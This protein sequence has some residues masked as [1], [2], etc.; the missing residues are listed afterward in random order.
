VRARR[1]VLIPRGVGRGNV[2]AENDVSRFAPQDA[3]DPWC[4]LAG[5]QDCPVGGTGAHYYLVVGSA[6]NTILDLKWHKDMTLI[7]ET[8]DHNPYDPE[9]YNGD[10]IIRLG[11]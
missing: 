9:T 2:I 10:N 6:N 8:S 3:P 4:R 7:D 11:K 1:A 5:G